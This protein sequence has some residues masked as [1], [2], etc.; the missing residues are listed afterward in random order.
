MNHLNQSST[1]S[2]TREP[3]GGSLDDKKHRRDTSLLLGIQWRERY[4]PNL[5]EREEGSFVKSE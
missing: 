2:S 4:L 3:L 5:E 1:L